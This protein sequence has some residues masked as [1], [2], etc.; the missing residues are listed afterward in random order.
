MPEVACSCM[1][2]GSAAV[3]ALQLGCFAG[4]A[5]G[6]ECWTP[7]LL[8]EFYKMLGPGSG[9]GATGAPIA[10]LLRDGKHIRA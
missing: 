5:H 8:L 6:T 4:S 7:V 9:L 1:A 3:E 10:R 2:S